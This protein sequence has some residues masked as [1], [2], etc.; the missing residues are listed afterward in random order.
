MDVIVQLTEQSEMAAQ[1]FS[2]TI[3]A[4]INIPDDELQSYT[5]HA[6]P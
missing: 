3:F 1:T 5:E 4:L 6:H 2:E